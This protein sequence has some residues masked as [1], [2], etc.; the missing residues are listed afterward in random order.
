MEAPYD[1]LDRLPARSTDK[2]YTL[3]TPDGEQVT[4]WADCLTDA[5]EA[6]REAILVGRDIHLLWVGTSWP[7]GTP[8]H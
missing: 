5:R 7:A 1:D 2:R 4:V 8:R 6:A 3:Q